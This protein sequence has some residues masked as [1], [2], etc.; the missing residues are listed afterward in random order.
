MTGHLAFTRDLKHT[1]VTDFGALPP[2]LTGWKP[3]WSVGF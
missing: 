1:A 3:S 2:P